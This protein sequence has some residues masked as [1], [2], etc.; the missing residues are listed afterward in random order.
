MRKPLWYITNCNIAHHRATNPGAL[1]ISTKKGFSETALILLN[2]KALNFYQAVCTNVDPPRYAV[3]KMA[4]LMIDLLL[5]LLPDRV[6][7]SK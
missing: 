7:I 3:K 1:T 4:L 5:N 6:S 2:Y